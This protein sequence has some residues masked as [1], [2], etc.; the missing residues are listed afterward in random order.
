MTDKS[1][2]LEFP[3]VENFSPEVPIEVFGIGKT[4]KVV[5]SV[6]TGSTGFLQ[7]PLA[8][9]IKANLRLFG[10]RYY[11]LADGRKVKKL[12]CIGKIRF[13]GKE[14]FGIISLSET[15][16][17]CLLGMQFLEA[18]GMDF[19]VSPKRNRA[20]FKLL[21]EKKIDVPPKRVKKKAKKKKK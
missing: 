19:T 18:L 12:E 16:D 11:Q 3:I 1:K 20:I 5:A 21:L 13:A 4:I 6:D 2:T 7:I 8:V 9:G 15:S 17:D 10:T 14:L